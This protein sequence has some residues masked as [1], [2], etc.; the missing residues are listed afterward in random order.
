[1]SITTPI[2]FWIKIVFVTAFYSKKLESF[3]SALFMFLAASIISCS[4][5]ISKVS[6]KKVEGGFKPLMIFLEVQ[7]TH[8]AVIFEILLLMNIAQN[9]PTNAGS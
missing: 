9:K 6:Y 5:S 8:A 1:M 7:D 2:S 3:L 4:S